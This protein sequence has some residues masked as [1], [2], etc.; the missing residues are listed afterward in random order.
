M[1]IELNSADLLAVAGNG[2]LVALGGAVVAV[3]GNEMVENMLSW[4]SKR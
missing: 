3:G 4:Y 2:V 1:N